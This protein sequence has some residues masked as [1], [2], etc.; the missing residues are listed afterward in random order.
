M[1]QVF[2]YA[3]TINLM[4]IFITLLVVLFSANPVFAQVT[5]TDVAQQVQ[6]TKEV[7][8]GTVLCF[9]KEGIGPCTFSYDSGLYAVSTESPAGNIAE[10]GTPAP[11]S[12]F[13][14]QKG[15]ALV[16]V[17]TANGPIV[18]GDFL[19]SSNVEGVAQ[20][21]SDNGFV[22]GQALEDYSG[23]GEGLIQV[24]LNVHQTTAF[25]DVRSNLFELIRRGISA[26]VLTPLS[27]LRY[28]LSTVVLITSFILGF[29][30]FGRMARVSVEA[31]GRNPLAS[32]TIQFSI[33]LN[34]FVMLVIFCIGLALAYLILAI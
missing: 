11:N 1:L 20:K 18:N 22:L 3:V 24:S 28:I 6:L 4:I 27:V 32:R 13:V 21:A 12:F 19:T 8:N 2:L 33:V 25:A 31:I 10:I 9:L 15:T 14:V 34:I 30:Y 26:P 5:A 23:E 17:S 29:V 7:T 16:R